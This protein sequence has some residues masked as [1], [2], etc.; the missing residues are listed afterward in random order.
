MLKKIFAFLLI[1]FACVALSWGNITVG[2]ETNPELAGLNR[3]ID[4]VQEITK[5]QV[6]GAL[7]ASVTVDNRIFTESGREQIAKQHEDFVDNIEQIGDGLRNNIVTKSIENAITDDTRNII[8]TIG[9]YIEQDRQMTELQEK[10]QDLVNALNGLTNY[11]S[12]EAR[13]ILQQVADF[14]AAQMDSKA[15]YIWLVSTEML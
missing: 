7:D 8:D 2:G 1:L 9:D 6:T 15:I 12:A 14:V 10:R 13:D 4:N 11:D 5:D 3:D